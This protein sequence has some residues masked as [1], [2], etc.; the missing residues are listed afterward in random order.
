MPYIKRERRKILDPLIHDLLKTIGGSGE[1]NYVFSK[2]LYKLY[3]HGG[4]SLLNDAVG[5][6]ECTKLEFYRRVIV[7]YEIQKIKENGDVY[8][9]VDND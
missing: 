2:I 7:P 1:V 8:K 3:S 5:I 4:Y 6:L 9:E